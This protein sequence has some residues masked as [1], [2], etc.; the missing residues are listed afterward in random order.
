MYKRI[1]VL[2]DDSN[3]SRN[4]LIKALELAE[5]FNSEVELFNVTKSIK[6][7]SLC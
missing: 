1:L 5:K 6:V 7:A 2:T 4:A 3:G